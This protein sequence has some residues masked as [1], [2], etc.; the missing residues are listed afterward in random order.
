MPSPFL[1]SRRKYYCSFDL[2]LIPGTFLKATSTLSVLLYLIDLTNLGEDK[3]T[4]S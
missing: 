4:L 2:K 3:T 1:A